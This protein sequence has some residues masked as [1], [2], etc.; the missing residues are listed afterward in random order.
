MNNTIN[1][2]SFSGNMAKAYLQKK[3]SQQAKLAAEKTKEAARMLIN[4]NQKAARSNQYVGV[5]AY[6]GNVTTTQRAIGH[7]KTMQSI[8]I[9]K[10]IV[11]K[12]NET[13]PATIEPNFNFFG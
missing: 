5:G 8:A 13:K 9:S 7:D 12:F 1:A 10:S 2:V 3:A 11:P 4:S 6:F